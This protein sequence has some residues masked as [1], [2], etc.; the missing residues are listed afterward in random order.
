VPDT[1]I[2]SLRGILAQCA[3]FK[4]WAG[5]STHTESLAR[6]L[7][8]ESKLED[9]TRP[10]AV[11]RFGDSSYLPMAGGSRTFQLPSGMLSIIFEDAVADSYLDTSGD[12]ADAGGFNRAFHEAIAL[13]VAELFEQFGAPGQLLGT[14]ARIV[15]G[16][17]LSGE[18]D[19]DPF[20]QL[21]V[22]VEYGLVP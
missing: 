18:D 14:S 17:A 4:D 13:V 22:E 6:I 1:P 16:P 9:A 21:V 15:E 5:V 20:G 2:V 10:F 19:G 3:S 11:V 7:Y 12:V 8:E